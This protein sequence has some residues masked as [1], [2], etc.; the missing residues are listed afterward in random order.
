MID[1]LLTSLPHLL[2]GLPMTCTRCAA[3]VTPARRRRY[4]LPRH[5]VGTLLSF[6]PR[7]T[8][9]TLSETHLYGDMFIQL[10][11]P[12][13]IL[14]SSLQHLKIVHCCTS[15]M[16]RAWVWEVPHFA[17]VA[18]SLVEQ[19]CDAPQEVKDMA[20]AFDYYTFDHIADGI[21]DNERWEP[22]PTSFEEF[23][24]Y[25]DLD[26]GDSIDITDDDYHRAILTRPLSQTPFA[27]LNSLVYAP[28]IFPFLEVSLIFLTNLFPSLKSLVLLYEG[29][30]LFPKS[31]LFVLRRSVCG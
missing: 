19:P 2:D 5:L 17:G 28:R 15:L 3:D 18:L 9:L 11:G 13:T 30:L 22:Q 26:G 1:G 16:A 24:T 31:F 6:A 23:S 10:L 8:S 12:G 20:D 29:C 21:I 14:R 7:L 27:W 4:A 25:F